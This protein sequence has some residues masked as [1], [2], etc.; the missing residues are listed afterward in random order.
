MNPS[1][2]SVHLPVRDACQ[3]LWEMLMRRIENN[4]LPPQQESFEA[5]LVVRDSSLGKSF[6]AEDEKVLLCKEN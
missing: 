2:T 1:L 5:Y 6:T 3:R 4:S